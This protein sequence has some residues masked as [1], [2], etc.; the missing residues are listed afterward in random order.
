MRSDQRHRWLGE[1]PWQSFDT[2]KSFTKWERNAPKINYEE[3]LRPSQ[4]VDMGPNM[5]MSLNADQRIGTADH[6]NFGSQSTSNGTL[7]GVEMLSTQMYFCTKKSKAYDAGFTFADETRSGSSTAANLDGTTARLWPAA[8]WRY[9]MAE[10]RA[11]VQE[12]YWCDLESLMEG[13][14]ETYFYDIYLVDPLTSKKDKLEL[15]PLPVRIINLDE[16][17][18]DIIAPT[19]RAMD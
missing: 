4:G 18:N 12:A 6:L 1:H 19:R 13:D 15:Y 7:I 8:I 17:L 9:A 2:A 5:E 3:Q 10:A 16:N 14:T 11:L